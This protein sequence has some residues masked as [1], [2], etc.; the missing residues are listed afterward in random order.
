MWKYERFEK[1]I[2]VED[3]LEGYVAEEEFLEYC[4]ACPNYEKIWAC[5]SYDFD[6]MAYWKNYSRLTVYAR[7]IYFDPDTTEAES[8]R[9][10]E[11]V[12]DDMSRELFEKEAEIPGS[13]SLCAGSC[14]ICGKGNCTRP[15]GKACR[16]PERMRYSLES[17]GANV[18]M[19]CR[20]LMGIQLEWMEEG[21]VPP[22][23]V[24]AAGLLQ[25]TEAQNQED[26]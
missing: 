3:Y 4:K 24:L 20:K 18:G 23:F 14:S 7:K 26:V 8:M 6:V 2:S 1:E 5:P 22:Y 10:M 12:K 16:Y 9:I 19:T 25:K 17:L 21:K 11:E 15:E 13:V